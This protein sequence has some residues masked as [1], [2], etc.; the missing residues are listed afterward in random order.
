MSM[1]RTSAVQTAVD[2]LVPH[3]TNCN[4]NGGDLDSHNGSRLP[5]LHAKTICASQVTKSARKQFDLLCPASLA[6]NQNV[7]VFRLRPRETGDKRDRSVEF[8]RPNNE[9]SPW[10]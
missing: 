2:V 1:F 8:V 7:T 4:P 6:I 5:A 3:A 10:C 9:Q